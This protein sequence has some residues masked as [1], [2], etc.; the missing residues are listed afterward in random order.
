MIQMRF[1][2]TKYRIVAALFAGVII[3]FLPFTAH[4]SDESSVRDVVQQVFQQLQSRNYGAVYDSL[5]S[6]TRTRMARERFVSALKRAQ[7]RYVLDRINVGKVRVSGNIAVADT[8]LFGRVT[9]P[10]DAEGKIVV[11]QYLVREGGKWR[12]AT[13]DTGTIQR[14]LKTNP[15]FARQFPI[16]QPRIYVKQNGNWVEFNVG[17]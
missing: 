1:S 6:S 5:P 16:K 15:A 14:F 12:V 8:E 11:Q 10:F 2:I 9:K 13:G 4:A 7:D 3:G 17:R